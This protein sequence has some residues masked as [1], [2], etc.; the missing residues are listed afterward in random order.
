[1]Q[2][3]I[4]MNEYIPS[5]AESFK[6]LVDLYSLQCTL[7]MSVYLALNATKEAASAPWIASNG[8]YRLRNANFSGFVPSFGQAAGNFL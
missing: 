5:H 1:M 6:V 4:T 8:P 7:K 3:Q 2:F